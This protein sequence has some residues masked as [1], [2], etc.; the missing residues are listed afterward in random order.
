MIFETKDR[1]QLERIEKLL[2]ENGRKL[3]RVL[4][5]LRKPTTGL[6]VLGTPVKQ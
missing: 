2:K 1:E 3:D 6:I 5:Q 4:V